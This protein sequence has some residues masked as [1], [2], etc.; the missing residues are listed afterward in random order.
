MMPLSTKSS[1]FELVESSLAY[2]GYASQYDS[3]VLENRI[4]EIGRAHV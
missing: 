1:S 2:D 3:L 4:N